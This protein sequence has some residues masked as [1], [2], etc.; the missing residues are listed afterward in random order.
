MAKQKTL[1]DAFHAGL[2]DVRHQPVTLSEVI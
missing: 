2:K 1:E